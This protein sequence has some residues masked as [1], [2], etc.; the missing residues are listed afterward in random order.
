MY[1]KSRILNVEIDERVRFR[2]FVIMKG[3]KDKYAGPEVEVWLPVRDIE[4]LYRN[5]RRPLLKR[6]LLSL[7]ERL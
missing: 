2:A 5:T 7:A 1:E 4:R 6:L 3:E